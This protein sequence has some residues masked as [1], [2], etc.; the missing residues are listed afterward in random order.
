MEQNATQKTTLLDAAILR[1]NLKWFN[2][3]VMLPKITTIIFAIACFLLGIIFASLTNATALLIFWGGGLVF[4]LLNYAI[5]KLSLSYQIL[6][7]Y[8]LKHIVENNIKTNRH[9]TITS[10]ELPEI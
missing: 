3:F 6:H 7:I 8:Y 2:F 4:C 10:D 5:L 9:E 1:E